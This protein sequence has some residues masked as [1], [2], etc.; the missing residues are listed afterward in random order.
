MLAKLFDEVLAHEFSNLLYFRVSSRRCDC[1]ASRH[2][3]SYAHHSS[4]RRPPYRS[5]LRSRVR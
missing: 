3:E 5:L 2:A 1:Y 4:P